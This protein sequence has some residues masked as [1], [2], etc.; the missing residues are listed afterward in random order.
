MTP[1]KKERLLS[2]LNRLRRELVKLRNVT[3]REG[4]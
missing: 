1:D 4:S 2:S 3:R